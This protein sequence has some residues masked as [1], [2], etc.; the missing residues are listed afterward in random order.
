MKDLGDDS[1]VVGFQIRQHRFQGILG[2]SQ[3][4]N[5]KKVFKIF[6]M[7]NCKLVNTL[8]ARGDKFSLIYCPKNELE[9]KKC[10][11]FLVHMLLEVLYMLK[12]V[13]VRI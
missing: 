7:Q 1:F 2:L 11:R 12:F 8:I 13:Q 5:I 10:K 3:K 9:V 6:N 4:S